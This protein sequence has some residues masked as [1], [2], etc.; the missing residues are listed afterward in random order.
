MM[1]HCCPA[2]GCTEQLPDTL[3]FCKKHWFKVPASLRKQIWASY[4][5]G[6]AGT[7]PH[8]ALIR[9]ATAHVDGVA[10]QSDPVPVDAQQLL[11]ETV[12]GYQQGTSQLDRWKMILC[13][14]GH[15]KY[16]HSDEH[17][18]VPTGSGHCT[19]TG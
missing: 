2:A 3:V 7:E 9:A 17:D 16:D 5:A 4:H 6:R 13:V 8:F 1:T 12:D 18:E 14:C 19:K 10:V 11:Q 15:S